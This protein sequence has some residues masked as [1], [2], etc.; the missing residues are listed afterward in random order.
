[1]DGIT[2][3]KWGGF[4][5]GMYYSDFDKMM[6]KDNRKKIRKT[7]VLLFDEISMCSGHLFDVLE[8]MVTIIRYYDEEVNNIK[9]KH[10]VKR[11]KKQAP[12]ITENMGGASSDDQNKEDSIMSSYML[13]MRFADPIL[14]QLPAWGGMQIIVVGDFFQLPPVPNKVKRNGSSEPLLVNDELSEIDY[15]NIVGSMGSYSFQS[16]SWSK[17]NFCT[18]ELVEIHRQS[19]NDDGL[20][21]LLNAMREGQLPLEQAHA[22]AIQSIK[23]PLR[24]NTDGIVPTQLHSKNAD[25][26]EINMSE[27][28]KLSGEAVSF[29][30]KDTV[31]FAG[32]Y[33]AKMT[34]KYSL[35]Q[36]SHLPQLWSSIEG[37]TYPQRYH[38]AKIELQNLKDK[39]VALINERKYSDL[40]DIDKQKDELDKEI[41]DIANTTE[42]NNETNLQNVTTW[43]NDANVQGDPVY[44]LDQITQ[45]ENQLQSDFKKFKAHATERFFSTG[46]CR[47]DEE[48]VLKEEAQVMLLYNLDLDAKL[49]NGSR[50][51]IEGFV[52]T[53]EYKALIKAI[54]D[55][56]DNTKQPHV[57]NGDK[58][59]EETSSEVDDT[60]KKDVDASSKTDALAKD[61]HGNGNTESSQAQVDLHS[62]ITTLVDKELVD[63]LIRRIMVMQYINEELTHIERALAA[64]MDKLPLVKFVE[65]QLQV[66]IPIPFKK[67]FKG[68]GEASRN[69]IPLTLAWA[70]S[71]HKSQGMTIDLLHVSLDGCFAPGQAYVAC[72][73]GRSV[74]SMTVDKWEESRIITSDLVKE[75]YASLHDTTPTFKPPTWSV[76]LEDAKKEEQIKEIMNQR[77]GN[78]VCNKCGSKCVVYKIKK[79]GVN[80][81]RW[82]VQCKANLELYRET[83]T[84]EYNHLWEYVAAPPMV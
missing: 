64:N 75:F 27:L 68:C 49:A 35:E 14:Q 41:S 51:I 67:L 46:E 25:V 72:S 26:R 70:I 7:D 18:I 29:N 77:F 4:G 53:E 59:V 1:V 2:V 55:K 81:G 57:S 20:L 28:G 76:M 6:A 71:I 38:D 40:P 34:K 42:S 30:A 60:T 79:K 37:I 47:V 61:S 50:G 16:S 74:E 56:R 45:F 22:K 44:F 24:K 58:K 9:I 3:H 17:T 5:I 83:N 62:I 15:N 78:R 82:V 48:M 84:S 66:I 54:M 52:K 33:K 11:I 39:H 23:S 19:D 65:G 10:V 73:R 8:C 36:I 69:Q 63:A 13:K 80:Q 32:R 12:I 43:L 21:K 31:E